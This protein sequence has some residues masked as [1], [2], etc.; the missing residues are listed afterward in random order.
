MTIATPPTNILGRH[1]RRK[2]KKAR[3]IDIHALIGHNQSSH[4]LQHQ[5]MQISLFEKKVGRIK[6]KTY[7]C[8]EKHLGI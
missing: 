2:K 3:Y 4:G 7:F 8:G 6:Y 5:G 1:N